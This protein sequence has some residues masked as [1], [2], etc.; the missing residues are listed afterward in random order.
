MDFKLGIKAKDSITGFQG[1][2]TGKVSYLTGC[3][4]YLLAPEVHNCWKYG[5]GPAHHIKD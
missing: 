4:Q 3:D 1:V 5:E 2:I